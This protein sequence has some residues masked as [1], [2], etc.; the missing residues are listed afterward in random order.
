MP[1]GFFAQQFIEKYYPNINQLLVKDSLEAL[2]LLSLGKADATIDKK[3]VLDYLISTK[4]ISQVVPSNYVND[5]RSISYISVATSKDKPLLNSILNKAQNAISDEEL[6][7]LKRKWFGSNE[8]IDKK[9][10]LTNYEKNYLKNNSTIKMC[11]I[12]ELKPIE[13]EEDKKLQGI[14]IDL[15]SLMAK[16]LDI[17]I[18]HVHTNNIKGT[19]NNQLSRTLF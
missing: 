2:E 5:E 16:K 8:I 12:T 9:K 13:F 17:N 7:D 19:S 15:L 18:E 14:N 4:N 10:F 6:L 1:K 11:N 3:N